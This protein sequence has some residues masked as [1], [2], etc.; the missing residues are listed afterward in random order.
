MS[1]LRTIGELLDRALD[2]V[3]RAWSPPNTASEFAGV[4]ADHVRF[5]DAAIRRLIRERYRCDAHTLRAVFDAY[6]GWRCEAADCPYR[7][8]EDGH[9]VL[10]DLMALDSCAA[11]V[12]AQAPHSSAPTEAQADWFGFP[13]PGGVDRDALLAAL[14]RWNERLFLGALA[15]LIEER[16][17]C[18][19]PSGLA[20]QVAKRM[21]EA[22]PPRRF[23]FDDYGQIVLRPRD[24]KAL[25]RYARLAGLT[26]SA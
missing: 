6:Q 22:S 4:V 7:V 16:Y 14:S 2:A 10:G 12:G 26:V 18:S 21:R 20:T 15:S 1:A 3:R 25:D 8:E 23:T 17:N 5:Y 9:L 24:L 13:A 11:E 19:R